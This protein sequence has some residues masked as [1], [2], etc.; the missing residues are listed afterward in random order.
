MLKH[1]SCSRCMAG[2]TIL[3]D[4]HT[5]ATGGCFD[6]SLTLKRT[7]CPRGHGLGLVVQ[8]F[9][10]EFLQ[11]S[12]APALLSVFAAFTSFWLKYV[13]LYNIDNSASLDAASCS[14]FSVEERDG[15]VR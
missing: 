14:S 6:D 1:L 9:S 12:L 13:D 10:N 8:I 7:S 15:A 2:N 4:L 11:H 5:W 3:R